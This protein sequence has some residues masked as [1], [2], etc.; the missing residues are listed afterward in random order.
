MQNYGQICLK[1]KILLKFPSV[2][3]PTVPIQFR[4][5]EGT[6][7]AIPYILLPAGL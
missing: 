6:L 5:L 2:Q 1:L 3:F 7:V 4:F